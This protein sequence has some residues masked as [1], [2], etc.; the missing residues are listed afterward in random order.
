M[1]IIN[2]MRKDPE[3]GVVTIEQS[4]DSPNVILNPNKPEIILKGSSFPEDAVEFYSPVINWLNENENNFNN[5]LV[6]EFNYSILSSASNKMV[7]EILLKL[8]KLKEKGKDIYVKWFYSGYDEDMYDEGR[9]FK[10]SMN[11]RFDLIEK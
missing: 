10:D 3:T 8:E 1:E 4:E 9:G 6:C 5:T 2:K 7:F 11:L